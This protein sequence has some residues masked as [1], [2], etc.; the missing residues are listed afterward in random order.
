MPKFPIIL[1]FYLFSLLFLLP[2]TELA[3]KSPKRPITLITGPETR[4]F[5]K[6]IGKPL[7]AAA[8]MMPD[9]V[10][11]HVML[12]PTLNAMA[13]P[14]ND[15]IFNS[16]LLLRTQSSA[17]VASV[18]AHEIA[19]L[20]AGHH[21]KLQSEMKNISMQTLLVSIAGIAAGALSGSGKVA[22]A[23]IMGGTATGHAQML[24]GQRQKETQADRLAI[25]FLAKAGFD[26]HGM[27]S[28]M[29]RMQR[30]QQG[31]DLPPPYLLSHP[32]SST[33]LVEIRQMAI[34]I[35]PNKTR[36]NTRDLP[37]K[38]VQAKLLAG[39]VETPNI[40]VKYFRAKLGKVP[41]DLISQYGL[42]V[43]FRYAGLLPESEAQLTELLKRYPKDPY[44]YRERGRTRIDW[45]RALQAEGDFRS[46]LKYRPK[47]QDLLYWLAF[48]LK[49]QDKFKEAGRIL[50]RLTLKHPKK[51]SYFY[52]LGMVEGKGKQPAAGHLALGRYYALTLENPTALWHFDESI[53][54]FP[55][56]TIGHAIA[57]SEKKHLL[58]QMGKKKK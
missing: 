6:E 5:L 19:H 1:S 17:E 22:Q 10:R 36:T 51:A 15:I 58:A 28:F 37:L 42:A 44:L 53:R 49:V 12:D 40:A 30:D 54:L 34:E 24:S 38:R 21:I 7:L 2:A 32:L 39:T 56:N 16:G 46:A 52:L 9:S 55:T 23:A 25:H 4:D 29:E 48:S 20:S 14:S 31:V 35:R 8:G 47:D 3:A 41:N 43:A 45:G 33:R 57:R 27:T 26:P 50:R 13:L 18:M 11:F